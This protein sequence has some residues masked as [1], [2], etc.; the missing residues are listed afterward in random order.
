VSHCVHFDAQLDS[1]SSITGALA[2]PITLFS[3]GLVAVKSVPSCM[4]R[5]VH[6]NA[7]GYAAWEE[8]RSSWNANM[9]IRLSASDTIR[10]CARLCSNRSPMTSPD[11]DS[12]EKSVLE[13]RERSRAMSVDT[14]DWK[15]VRKE[16]S[17][18]PGCHSEAFA[19]SVYSQIVSEMLTRTYD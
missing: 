14:T 9:S 18:G 5:S 7:P 3:I 10:A 19:L 6:R 12:Q 8:T 17:Q 13:S 16:D 4:W 1:T 2:I 11:G 15:S